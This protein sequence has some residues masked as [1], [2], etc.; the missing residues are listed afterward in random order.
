V[1]EERKV[2][3]WELQ[4][5]QG[6]V[7]ARHAK[8]TGKGFR[9]E[10]AYTI[11]A[12]GDTEDWI[13]EK[14]EARVSDLVDTPAEGYFLDIEIGQSVLGEEPLEI[15]KY[16]YSGFSLRSTAAWNRKNS[17]MLTSEGRQHPE[18]DMTHAKWVLVQG[19]KDSGGEAGV[20]LMSHPE[21]H[22]HPEYLHTWDPG[23]AKGGVF[24]NFNPV[25]SESLTMHAGLEYIRRYRLFVFDGEI[26]SDAAERLW[27][28]WAATA[29]ES[30][31]EE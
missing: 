16:R 29:E 14:I 28:E 30:D 5:G 8:E 22:G 20:L 23:L 4:A 9:A 6:R 12:K 25:Q 27:K 21:N 11:F 7:E 18:S 24:V 31:T 2:L 3:F 17:I 10:S 19:P 26:D 1:K 15:L 13:R